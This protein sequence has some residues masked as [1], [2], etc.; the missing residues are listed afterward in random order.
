MQIENFIT[1][2]NMITGTGSLI[3]LPEE[4]VVF[5]KKILLVTGKKALKNIGIT[6]RIVNMLEEAG[7]E[8]RLFD[9]ISTEPEAWEIDQGRKMASG[10]DVVA[11]VGGGS[12]IDAAKAIAGLVNE[13]P[14]TLSYINGTGFV[15]LKPGVPFIA[16]PTT[17]G[18]GAE[19]TP[20]AVIS[21]KAENIKISI[22]AD[23]FMAKTIIIDPELTMSN[24]PEVTAYSGIDAMVQAVESYSSINATPLTRALSIEAFRLTSQSLIKAYKDGKDLKA[25]EDMAYGSLMAGIALANARLGLIHG[26]AHPM[27]VRYNIAHGKVCGILLP[28]ALRINRY[29]MGEGYSILSKTAG[30]DLH[31]FSSRLLSELNMPSDF[32]SYKIPES[33]FKILIEESLLSGSLKANPKKVANDDLLE[34][35]MAVC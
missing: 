17:A 7:C 29:A 1:S 13:T 21:C 28:Q 12:A 30:E 8:V 5:G 4:V 10:M 9:N 23:C 18:A 25:R 31:D 26:L 24:S 3:K 20:N 15:P 19:A 11:G 33:D 22:R 6:D 16:V 32:K 35:L 34:I 2:N 27:G 14:G